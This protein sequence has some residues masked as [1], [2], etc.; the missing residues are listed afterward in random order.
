MQ[1]PAARRARINASEAPNSAF[2]AYKKNYIQR[3]GFKGS[4]SFVGRSIGLLIW[5]NKSRGDGG[6][7]RARERAPQR[8]IVCV[9]P[10]RDS[11]RR[12]ACGMAAP[13][14]DLRTLGCSRCPEACPQCA[15]D[16]KTDNACTSGAAAVHLR[17][18]KRSIPQNVGTCVAASQQRNVRPRVA[19]GQTGEQG[20][21]THDADRKRKRHSDAQL[22]YSNRSLTE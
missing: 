16:V 1:A 19:T 20:D 8:V 4:R 9:V 2:C 12:A 22:V 18:G 5:A 10:G 11:R 17:R 15:H 6:E 7:G 21:G 13:L 3:Y 14:W